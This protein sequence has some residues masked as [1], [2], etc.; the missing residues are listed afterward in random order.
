M[1]KVLILNGS[2]R[3][4]KSTTGVF[5]ESFVNH[6]RAL[7][8]EADL[9]RAG[10]PIGSQEEISKLQLLLET[11][12][13]IGLFFPLYV[14][15]L[16]SNLLSW[17]NAMEAILNEKPRPKPLKVFY[18][19]QCGYPITENMKHAVMNCRFFTEAIHGQWLGGLSYGGGVMI[20]GRA[21]KELGRKGEK[22]DQVFKDMAACIQAGSMIPDAVTRPV[23]QK[24]NPFLFF[25]MVPLLNFI[26][27]Q[28]EKKAG[29]DFMSRP[30]N[31]MHFDWD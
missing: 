7:G 15:S 2:P 9:L 29:L 5:T 30:Y 19:T 6:Y 31:N 12:D 11:A 16:P 20:N 28:D 10:E 13:C 25:L 23:Y 3:K 24:N 27:R 8:G 26:I 17:M 14:D 21:L 22:L 1:N 4:G 18:T